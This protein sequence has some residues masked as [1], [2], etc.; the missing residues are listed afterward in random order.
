MTPLLKVKTLIPMHF[1]TF[2]MLAGTP[3]QLKAERVSVQV[4]V[5]E[6]GQPQ[7]L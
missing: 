6:P 3:D 2:P 5:L 7:S 1:G 4:M